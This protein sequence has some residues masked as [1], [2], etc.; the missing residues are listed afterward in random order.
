MSDFKHFNKIRSLNC[1]FLIMLVCTFIIL[2]NI[3][4]ASHYYR[5]FINKNSP[6]KLSNETVEA[7]LKL[8]EELKIYILLEHSESSATDSVK[9]DLNR[10]L[11]EYV[12]C[13]P[14]YAISVEFVDLGHESETLR[15]LSAITGIL[16]TNVVVLRMGSKIKVLP[17]EEFYE[18]RNGEVIGFCGER[19]LT[20]AIKD[21]LTEGKKIVYFVTGHGE[22]DLIDVSPI[23]GL[24]TLYAILRQRNYDLRILDFNDIN[25]VP[26][27]ADLVVIV[28]Q[29]VPFLEREISSLRKFLDED[30]G[31]LIVAIGDVDDHALNAFIADHGIY[32]N[33][34]FS[35]LPRENTSKFG[36]DLIVKKYAQ[37][38]ITNSLI[39]LKLPI[40]FG[41]TYEVKEAD[42][43]SNADSFCIT[44]L[45]Q[46]DGI[47]ERNDSC[48]D[49]SST[50]FIVASLFE[51]SKSNE[52]NIDVLNGKM[53]V[54]GCSDFIT[55]SKINILGNKILFCQSVDFMCGSDINMSIDTIEIN[56]CRLSLNVQQYI[57]IIICC[58]ALWCAIIFL[59][60]IVCFI[61]RK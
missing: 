4:S 8:K 15:S 57:T 37:H 1:I 48:N 10:L 30:G 29:K 21:L 24:S 2:I 13:E 26:V 61:R 17:I 50:E 23:N 49:N 6:Y 20:S 59:G 16:P 22:Y 45:I 60:F 40:V 53:L 36:N 38:K 44:D 27:D 31:N 9:N 25:Y 11:N 43:V 7:M 3:F 41:H 54:F 56:H 5:N 47:Y 52:I 19:L 42:W 58:I 33:H 51:K 18:I 28:G 12:E 35:I 34:A 55:N 14:N 39:N 46:A 32:I